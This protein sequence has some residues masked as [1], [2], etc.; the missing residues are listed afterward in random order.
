MICRLTGQLVGFTDGAV[1][2]QIGG[3]CYEV[4]VPPLLVESLSDAPGREL[5]LH[6]LQYLEGSPA[7]NQLIPRLIGFA[8][9]QDRDFFLALLRVRGLSTRRALR[10]MRLPTPAIAAAIEHGDLALLTSLPEIGRK[11]AQA[12]LNELRGSLAAFMQGAPAQTSEPELTE[13]QRLAVEILVQWGDRRADAQR[14]VQAAVRQ[15]PS[16]TEPQD[17]VRAAYRVKQQ[18]G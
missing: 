7:G 9:E 3:V 1:M 12:M 6:T 8:T 2:L 18:A 4:L 15:D 13:P 14:W 11:T 16:L 10:A 17:I 5:T